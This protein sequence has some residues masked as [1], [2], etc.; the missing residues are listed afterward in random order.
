VRA[1]IQVGE[2]MHPG[3]VF[4]VPQ[5]PLRT[6]AQAMVERHIPAVV[7]SNLSHHGGAVLRRHISS[8]EI[9]DVLAT[10]P[11]EIRGIFA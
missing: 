7:V 3:I 8:G 6:V 9:E 11:A 4:C 2:V 10:L 1:D 5:A